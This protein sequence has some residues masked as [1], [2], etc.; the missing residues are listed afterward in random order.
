[1]SAHIERRGN[2]GMSHLA[3][4]RPTQFARGIFVRTASGDFRPG[5]DEALAVNIAKLPELLRRRQ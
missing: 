5:R 3:A 1:M 4:P 2:A